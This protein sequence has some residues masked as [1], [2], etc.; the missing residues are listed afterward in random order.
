MLISGDDAG[1]MN[2]IAL[3]TQTTEPSGAKGQSSAKAKKQSHIR[4][5]RQNKR[6][7]PTSG[8]MADMLSKLFGK[9][10]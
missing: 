3:R 5:A 6:N 4:Q 8:P 1:F 10:D 2:R 9:K 7:V